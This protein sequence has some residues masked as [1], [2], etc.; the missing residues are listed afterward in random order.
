MQSFFNL[1]CRQTFLILIKKKYIYFY[2]TAQADKIN[3]NNDISKY[4]RV[5]I[6]KCCRFSRG[7]SIILKEK[8]NSH[9]VKFDILTIFLKT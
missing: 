4:D 1:L 3:F 6:I 8:N 9:N 5:V 7:Q 2:Q